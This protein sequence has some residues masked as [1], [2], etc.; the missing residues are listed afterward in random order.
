M[1][2]S[3]R[4][5]FGIVDVMLDRVSAADR[6]DDG[7]IIS[8]QSDVEDVFD[9]KIEISYDSSIVCP[10]QTEHISEKGVIFRGIW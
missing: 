3:P 9:S 8:C 7:V 2:A 4:E 6:W 10:N 5:P 1:V